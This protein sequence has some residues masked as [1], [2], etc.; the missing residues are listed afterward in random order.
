MRLLTRRYIYYLITRRKPALL[1][2]FER[3]EDDRVTFA[4]VEINRL[5]RLA[6]ATI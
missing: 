4:G 3:Q 1:H 2:K 6:E 5:C